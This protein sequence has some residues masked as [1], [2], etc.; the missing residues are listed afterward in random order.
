[1]E[2]APKKKSV[3]KRI[4]RIV[5]KTVMWI[6]LLIIVLFLLILT[7]PVQKFITNK[8]TDYLENK[9]HTR[10]EIGRLFI[11]L[12]GKIAIDD[13]YLEDQAKDTLLSAGKLRVNMSFRKLL[14]GDKKLQNKTT[15]SRYNVQFPV[16][17]RCIRRQ[18]AGFCRI[19]RYLCRHAD[20]YRVRGIEQDPVCI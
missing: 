20:R 17:R 5:L 9:L 19:N 14:F 13:I 12:T 16:H 6:F 11:T 7:P 1:M 18:F 10:V 8:A 3:G 4:L 15:P 2:Q